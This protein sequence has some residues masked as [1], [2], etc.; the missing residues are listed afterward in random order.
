MCQQFWDGVEQ[1]LCLR[2]LDRKQKQLISV[3]EFRKVMRRGWESCAGIEA[4][5]QYFFFVSMNCYRRDGG[6]AGDMLRVSLRR[7]WVS[8]FVRDV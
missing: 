2:M 7:G 5:R 8:S 1:I 6:K 3:M 4:I